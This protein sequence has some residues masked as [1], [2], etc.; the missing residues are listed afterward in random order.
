MIGL[1][2]PT[3]GGEVAEPCLFEDWSNICL[4]TAY[5]GADPENVC[6]LQKQISNLHFM[7]LAGWVNV[8]VREMRLPSTLFLL[9][10]QQYN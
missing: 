2:I 9:I 6:I 4:S 8:R 5:V 1:P 3:A 10:Q 7:S